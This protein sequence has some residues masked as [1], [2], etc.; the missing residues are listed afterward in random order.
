LQKIEDEDIRLVVTLLEKEKAHRAMLERTKRRGGSGKTNQSPPVR[1]LMEPIAVQFTI[2]NPG[3]LSPFGKGDSSFQLG[4]QERASMEQ[5][6]DDNARAP[7][8]RADEQQCTAAAAGTAAVALVEAGAAVEAT[9]VF[10]GKRLATGY[11]AMIARR[12]RL[13]K[14]HR[15]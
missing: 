9:A 3:Q 2:S 8:A 6:L 14:C 13:K 15:Y 10:S 5:V 7:G 1:A 12:R 11:D 4:W